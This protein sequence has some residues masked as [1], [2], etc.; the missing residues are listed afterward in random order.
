MMR[1]LAVVLGLLGAAAT[2]AAGAPPDG[3]LPSAPQGS[4]FEQA[5][6]A[7]D[8][9][10]PRDHGPHPAF[11]HEWWYLTGHLATAAGERFGFELTFFRIALARAA[12]SPAPAVRS[13]WRA[14]EIYVAHFAVTDIDRGRFRSSERYARSALALAGAEASPLHVWVGDWSLATSGG[15]WKIQAAQEGYELRLAMT[16]EVAPVAN[17]DHGLSQKSGAPADASYYYSIPRLAVHGELLRSGQPLDVDGHAWL[18]REWGSGALAADEAGWDWFALQLA[19]GSELMF[20][21]LRHRDGHEDAHSAGT[22]IAADGQVRAL[23]SAD[24]QIKVQGF[25]TSPRG[26]RYPAAWRVTVP[27][28]ALD[29]ELTPLLADQELNAKPR[30][31]EGAVVVKGTHER[32][33]IAGEGYV[34]LVGY[35]LPR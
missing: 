9:V 24:A 29:V 35:A 14:H 23:T 19:D 28:M 22:W 33:P 18:D 1:P 16:P 7:R 11:R 12:A 34:E 17:G 21:S 2:L 20:Y 32:R 13:H 25:W 26:G 4:G 8:F 10:F 5:R 31:W 3:I 30:Y 6:I 15:I 27:A